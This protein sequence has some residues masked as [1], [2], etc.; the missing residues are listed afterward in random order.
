MHTI[1]AVVEEWISTFSNG[2]IANQ[3]FTYEQLNNRILE[4]SEKD[5]NYI[6]EK[7]FP[8]LLEIIKRSEAPN[9]I[10]LTVA[11]IMTKLRPYIHDDDVRRG[12]FIHA[13]KCVNNF[14]R[15]QKQ[16][17]IITNL[18]VAYRKEKGVDDLVQI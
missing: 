7:I 6:V 1:E 18:M 14:L 5:I 3:L 17:R 9:E 2:S 4:Y 12:V 15:S 11:E 13:A 8:I 16:A 10:L